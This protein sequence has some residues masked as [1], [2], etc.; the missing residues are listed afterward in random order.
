M[1]VLLASIPSPGSKALE[2]GPL[3]LRAYG[4]MI[5]LGVLAA[6]EMG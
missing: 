3:S 1:L 5:A 4:L 2:I 6:I